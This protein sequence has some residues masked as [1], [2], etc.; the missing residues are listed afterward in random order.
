M[1]RSGDAARSSRARRVLIVDDHAA[2]RRELE[3]LISQEPDLIVCG[4]A[5]SAS[6]ALEQM[7]RLKPDLAVVDVT[8]GNT[9]GIELVKLM[10]SKVPH[11]AILMLSVHDESLY[12]L[13]ALK[14]G[15]SG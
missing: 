8:L 13:R 3:E 14:A 1:T 6:V 5:E 7:R 12:A 10:K 9:N 11:L 4:Q 2:F 15:A